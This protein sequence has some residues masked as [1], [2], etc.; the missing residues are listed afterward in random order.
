MHAVDVTRI[1]AEG[2]SPPCADGA[3]DS[4]LLDLAPGSPPSQ[5]QGRGVQAVK[6]LE[7]EQL[8]QPGQVVLEFLDVSPC[9]QAIPGV[10]IQRGCR[11]HPKWCGTR[12]ANP[13]SRHAVVTHVGL[14]RQA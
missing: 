10:G 7:D 2:L 9:V 12:R 6:L 4:F 11:E 3:N 8:Q 1:T 14:G 5:H 13:L